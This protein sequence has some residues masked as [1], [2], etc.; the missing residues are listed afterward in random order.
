MTEIKQILLL[1]GP[2]EQ[3]VEK[4]SEM[5]A[6]RGVQI[7]C[8]HGPFPK[9]LDGDFAY[10]RI[11]AEEVVIKLKKTTFS[12]SLDC[13]CGDLV[14]TI[15]GMWGANLKENTF[16]DRLLLFA[17]TSMQNINRAVEALAKKFGQQCEI[18]NWDNARLPKYRIDRLM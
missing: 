3:F 17:D 10:M 18:S 7:V 2:T 15:L 14:K 9:E 16:G 4:G 1:Q 5:V 11:G 6:S 13:S 8:H 12:Y